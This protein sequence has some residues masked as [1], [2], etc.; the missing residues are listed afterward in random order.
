M[1]MKW[2]RVC[3]W[4]DLWVVCVAVTSIK[5]Y[6]TIDV[7]EN[8]PLNSE[9]IE[10]KSSNSVGR[11]RWKLILLNL[12]GFESVYFGLNDANVLQTRHSIDREEFLQAK[13]CFDRLFCL[14]ELHILVNDGEEYL[15]IP[16]HIVE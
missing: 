3:L 9:V 6:P 14:I 10:L 12:A 1:K 16:I 8:V 7:R 13:R 11:S 15:V 2:V 4:L 5:T